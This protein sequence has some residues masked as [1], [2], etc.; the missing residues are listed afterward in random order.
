MRRTSSF[1]ERDM[2][3]NCGHASFHDGARDLAAGRVREIEC[4]G[5][6]TIEGDVESRTGKTVYSVTVAV[7]KGRTGTVIT[8]HCTCPDRTNCR[9][10]AAV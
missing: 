7:E 1:T 4:D 9:H 6:K 5:D 8:G 3:R 2:L 10:V